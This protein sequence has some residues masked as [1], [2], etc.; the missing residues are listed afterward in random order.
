MRLRRSACGREGDNSGSVHANRLQG[1]LG[2][3]Y[4]TQPDC[5][6]GDVKDIG[7]GVGKRKTNGNADGKRHIVVA[8]A[9]I[10]L[11]DEPPRFGNIVVGSDLKRYGRRIAN[12]RYA[13]RRIKRNRRPRRYRTRR[14]N[15]YVLRPRNRPGTPV[16]RRIPGKIAGRARPTAF[17]RKRGGD[18]SGIDT[19]N[20]AANGTDGRT[21]EMRFVIAQQ[22]S[23]HFVGKGLGIRR[24][25]PFALARQSRPGSAEKKGYG[26]C[27]IRIG[28]VKRCRRRNR[29]FSGH[30]E[31]LAGKR[32]SA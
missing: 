19:G 30:G 3:E 15:G 11:Q 12:R 25:R 13:L 7:S 22:Q 9:D 23:G 27:R 18:R 6:C 17:A 10:V 4:A 16:A 5:S 28:R 26:R 20:A 1:R 14:K 21:F 29:V 24:S 32:E 2:R 8:F 31:R